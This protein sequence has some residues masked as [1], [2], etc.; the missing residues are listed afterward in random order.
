[1]DRAVKKYGPLSSNEVFGFEPALALGGKS[2]LQNLKKLN[3]HVHMA[4]LKEFTN[5]HK[6]DLEGLGKIL[7]GENASFSKA[8]E[9]VS[10]TE[11]TH[12]QV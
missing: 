11:K 3:I 5:V 6:T 1:F 4:I 2:V 9:Q 12:S 10:Q 7:Y 8:I